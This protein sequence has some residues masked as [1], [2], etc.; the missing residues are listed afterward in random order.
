MP[1]KGCISSH[2]SHKPEGPSNDSL[3]LLLPIFI[4]FPKSAGVKWCL[5]CSSDSTHSPYIGRGQS[6]V[7]RSLVV[8]AV[9]TETVAR[10]RVTHRILSHTRHLVLPEF[11]YGILFG[12]CVWHCLQNRRAGLASSLSSL[13]RSLSLSG[14]LVI[15]CSVIKYIVPPRQFLF[16]ADVCWFD[17]LAFRNMTGLIQ[18]SAPWTLI[19]QGLISFR[20]FQTFLGTTHRCPVGSTHPFRFFLER[21]KS[22][23]QFFFCR[24]FHLQVI[25]LSLIHQ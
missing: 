20:F 23:I 11:Q 1:P 22:G 15:P 5:V 7:A 3:F 24:S 19:Q 13:S 4:P 17:R 14:R 2:T 9:S 8:P 10:V 12:L 6:E 25:H 16:H 21:L 18:S